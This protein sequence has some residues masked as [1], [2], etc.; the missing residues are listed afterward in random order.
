MRANA[1]VAWRQPSA[2][3]AGSSLRPALAPFVGAADPIDDRVEPLLADLA[4]RARL[5]DRPARDALYAAL[6]P[7]I[8][9]FVATF[10]RRALA[11]GGPRADGRPLDYD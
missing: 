4:R 1:P 5:G 10:H 8:E 9:R 7:K 11:A 3:A 2:P 6:A